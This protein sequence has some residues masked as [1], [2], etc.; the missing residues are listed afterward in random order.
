MASSAFCSSQFVAAP[1][2]GTM[3]LSVVASGIATVDLAMAVGG[4]GTRHSSM[5]LT[6]TSNRSPGQTSDTCPAQPASSVPYAIGSVGG[7]LQ[8]F[9]QMPYGTGQGVYLFEKQ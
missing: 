6:A 3:K 5:T 4:G 7:P 9:L 1:F 8:V 2:Q